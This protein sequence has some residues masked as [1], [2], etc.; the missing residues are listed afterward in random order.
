[1]AGI[2]HT[3]IAFKNGKLL[4]ELGHFTDGK[5]EQWIS[6]VPFNYN[7]DGEIIDCDLGKPYM[8]YEWYSKYRIINWVMRKIAKFFVSP[9]SYYFYQDEEKEVV[10]VCGEN[11]NVTYYIGKSDTYVLL[12]GYGHYQN[13]YTHFYKRGYGEEFER[14][15][16]KECYQWLCERVLGNATRAR[17]GISD[18]IDLSRLQ[19]RLCCKSYWDMSKEEKE[20]YNDPI[21]YYEEEKF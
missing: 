12:G 13:P 20:H 11:Y 17:Y 7:R 15:M 4:K 21:D 3:I 6:H 9:T 10:F 5:L 16:A 1:M 19:H 18:N 8:E 14:K 2:D